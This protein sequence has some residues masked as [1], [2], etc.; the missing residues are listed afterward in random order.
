V[1]IPT[2]HGL[3]ECF[4]LPTLAAQ[5]PNTPEQ[6]QYIEVTNVKHGFTNGRLT[7]SFKMNGAMSPEKKQR[8]IQR[9]IDPMLKHDLATKVLLAL[10]RGPH[11]VGI[12][13]GNGQFGFNGTIALDRPQAIGGRGSP[14][15]IFI[16]EK[17]S[18]WR[19]FETIV[20]HPD[21]GLFHELVHA[22]HNQSGA[23]VKDENE[24]ERRVIGL[25]SYLKCPVTENAYRNARDLPPRCCRDREQL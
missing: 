21:V 13:C 18:D 3:G 2:S 19:G 1:Y 23:A 4:P 22:L 8:F 11:P 15:I 5:R 17:A 25:G 7:T 9:F 16:D 14:S 24:A 6:I 12:A 20:T 10:N